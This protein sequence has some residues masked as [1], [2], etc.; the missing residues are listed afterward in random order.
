MTD[1]AAE[2][3]NYKKSLNLPKTAF[4]M[5]ANLVQNE[6]QSLKR[7]GRLG[8]YERT[9]AARSGSAPFV[10]HDGPPYANGSIHIGHLLN[11]CLK[12]FVVRSQTLLGRDCAFVP[13]WDCHGL[14]IEH[15]VMTGL[16]ESGKIDKLLA[17]DDDARRLA[18]RRECKASAEKFIKL[19]RGQMEKLL[20]LA[21]YEHPYVTM[22]PAY[23]ASVLEGFAELVE[24]GLV[25]R[26]LKAVHWSV[27]NETALAEAELEYMDR[28]DLSV[29]VEFDALDP[30]AVAKAF[31][32][33]PG[34]L[35]RTPTFMIWTTTPWTLPANLAI[36]VHP[37]FTYALAEIDGTLTVVAEDLLSSVT[38]G[39]GATD[40]RTLATTTGEKLVGLRYRHPLTDEQALTDRLHVQLRE[41]IAGAE[42]PTLY[43]I[44]PAE[45]VTLEDGTGLVHTA[46]GHGEEDYQTGLR[47]AL[48]IYCPVLGNGTYDDSAP[49]WLRG[50]LVWDANQAIADRL[51]DEGRLFHSNRFMHSYPHDWR[52]K[53]P[54]IFRA[55][56][57]W[58]VFV[59][60]PRK[61]GGKSLRELALEATADGVKFIPEWGRNRMRGMLDSRPDWCISRQ[62]SWGL[63]IPA[64]ETPD[65][66][67]LLTPA[68]VRAVADRV[69][70][71]GSDCW[72]TESPSELLGSYDAAADP[73]APDGLDVRALKKSQDIFDVWFES[74]SSWRAVMKQRGLGFPVQLYLEGSDQHRGWF[75]LSLLVGLGCEGR[76]P[77]NELLTHGFMVA[78]DGR[79]MSK[80]LGN[81]IEVEDL[82]K[83]Y[84]ADVCRWWVASL[85]FE[86][87]IKVDMEFFQT[88]GESYRKV[89]NTLRFMLSCLD[90][91][92]PGGAND[93]SAFP[94]TSIDAWAIGQFNALASFV[95]AAYERYDF[96]SAQTRL[97]QFCNDTL[98]AVYLAAVKD[99]LYC[100]RP[101][102]ERR[103]RTQA[104][105]AAITEGL[106]RLLAPLLPHTADEAW[107]ALRK[108]S[109]DSTV[110]LETIIEGFGAEIDEGWPRVMT[111]REAALKAL[112]VAREAKGVEAPLDAGVTL[113]DPEGVIDRFDPADIA[114]LIGVSRV[115]LD[116]NGAGVVVHDLRDE[117][118][119]ERSWKRD[120]TVKQRSDGGMLSDRDALAVGVA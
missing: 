96:K 38:A 19:Q 34:A 79:K 77:F 22:D 107:R 13:G 87:D 95:R 1:T 35:P 27:A 108:V 64:F 32:L 41:R 49:D 81:A 103:R 68:S 24:Q 63:P 5:K 29:F 119:C 62:R 117:P 47:E 65:G 60:E 97:Y 26:H 51:R 101:D 120:G 12:D 66:R 4:P 76:S 2:Q 104:A 70:A 102:S 36:A 15:K 7:W 40:V 88:A 116:P 30:G 114:D 42:R 73:D 92:E 115:S 10:F 20:T 61:G 17:L 45:Y 75:Q 118:R 98:S 110:H 39:P 69:R 52:G 57:Q 44:V 6:P 8:L 100:D 105:F 54:V 80:S 89:R 3:R 113:P 25:K 99:R 50:Q 86:N 55:T 72:F 90:D 93:V 46:P 43:R 112:E 23:E 111:S 83:E 14:P 82:L 106:C 85:A 37:R 94:P 67:A 78:K 84:G 28:E 74:G 9:R 53:T 58:F 18:I 11:K 109:D 21:D 59:D 71:R 48:P 33:E 16:V 56:E 31:G 91:F